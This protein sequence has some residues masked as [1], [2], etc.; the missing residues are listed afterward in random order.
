MRVLFAG[1]PD[2]AVPSL[3]A[4]AGKH[5]VVG[6]LTNPDSRQGRGKK[7]HHS[8]V[9]E[10]ALELGLNVLQPV[11][12]N[13]EFRDIVKDLNPDILVCF[14]YSKIFGPLFMSLFPRGGINLHPSKLPD[15]RGASP[16]NSIILRGD[17]ETA[18]TVQ[19]L[20]QEMD[21]GD[22]LLQKPLVI[23]DRE[24]THSLA[25]RVA[26]EG[27]SCLL[28]VLDGLESGRIT[29]VPQDH[30]KATFCSLIGKN[31]GLVDWKKPAVELDR[32]VRAYSP[33]PHGF[34]FWKGQR[35]NILEACPYD[36]GTQTDTP[37]QVT[38]LDKK[39]GILIQTGDG[40]LAVS[41]LQLQSKKALD[42]KSF[43]NGS[44]D[45]INS[46]LGAEDDLKN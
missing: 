38:G 17:R 1:T 15:L 24:T 14:A 7:V 26:N 19:T 35:L 20:A 28:E 36:G 4:L 5:E 43:L 30:S 41:R 42:F 11:K 12:L 8:P 46:V 23:D 22:I 6:V 29:P 10:A 31:D 45:F 34:T 3:R 37:G 13:G 27:G 18:I 32:V 33:W 25:E 2:I 44:K 39:E 9:K 40:I 21:S 16:L